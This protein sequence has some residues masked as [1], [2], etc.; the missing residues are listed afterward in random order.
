MEPFSA[1]FGILAFEAALTHAEHFRSRLYFH[2]RSKYI[3]IR[4]CAKKKY[5]CISFADARP[6]LVLS[7]TFWGRVDGGFRIRGGRV[8][9]RVGISILVRPPFFE[10]KESLAETKISQHDSL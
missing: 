7:A 10:G 2:R 4:R 5:D 3:P 1:F 6:V 9:G 8:V